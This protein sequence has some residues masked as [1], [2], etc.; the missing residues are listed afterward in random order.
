MGRIRSWSWRVFGWPEPPPEPALVGRKPRP[1]RGSDAVALALP[2][3]S[4][5]VDARGREL[6]DERDA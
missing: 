4:E 2:A 1:P 5:D 3:E 6:P